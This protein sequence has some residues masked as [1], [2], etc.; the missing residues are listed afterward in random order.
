M[1]DFL[2]LLPS[3]R[4]SFTKGYAS[5]RTGAVAILALRMVKSQIAAVL[6]TLLALAVD[7][8]AQD[9]GDPHEW[10]IGGK[11]RSGDVFYLFNRRNTKDLIYGGRWGVDLD[12]HS[13]SGLS[14]WMFRRKP[15]GNVTDHRE[16]LRDDEPLALYNTAAHEFLSYGY[17][18]WG[19]DLKW[20]RTAVYEWNARVDDA[21][22]LALFNAKKRAYVVYGDRPM[23]INLRWLSGMSSPG[24]VKTASVTLTAQPI[25]QGYVP[26]LGSFGDNVRGTLTKV[27]NP[28]PDIVVN[29]VKPGRSTNNCGD[30]AAIVTLG[31]RETLTSAEMT[32]AFGASAPRL[33]VTFLACGTSNTVLRV[34]Y[35]N[36]EYRLD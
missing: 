15:V 10:D 30:P 27:S 20:S 5:L 33:P 26:F 32:A 22:R 25:I 6:V 18:N 31:P 14:Q 8:A 29:F 36:I 2:S 21:G 16:F 7:A 4:S 17:Q 34:V 1:S 23:G 11:R 35:V 3:Q 19:I 12:W 28:F 13:I 24:G 9:S